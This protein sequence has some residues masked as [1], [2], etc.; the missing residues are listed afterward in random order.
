MYICCTCIGVQA[1]ELYEY[2]YLKKDEEMFKHKLLLIDVN[3][4]LRLSRDRLFFASS[5]SC[6]A[7][8]CIIVVFVI[9]S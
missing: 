9:I 2:K 4:F 1:E 7:S 6:S 8:D 3:S 5:S